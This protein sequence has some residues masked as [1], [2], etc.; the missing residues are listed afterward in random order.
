MEYE[1]EYKLYLK[2]RSNVGSKD[3]VASSI[4]SY[5]SYL[6]A[7]EEHLD[8]QINPSSLS[9]TSHEH[10]FVRELTKQNVVSNKTIANYRSAMRQYMNMVGEFGLERGENY[11]LPLYELNASS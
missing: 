4:S 2:E 5:V 8:I 1:E 6:R 7:V 10:G 3:V 11:Y 9:S